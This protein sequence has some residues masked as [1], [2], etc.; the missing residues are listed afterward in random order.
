MTSELLVI[1]WSVLG[2]LVVG[3]I[4]GY[5]LSQ[6]QAEKG[7]ESLSELIDELLDDDDGI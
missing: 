7:F 1:A 3:G 2:G 4:G 6:W 5:L